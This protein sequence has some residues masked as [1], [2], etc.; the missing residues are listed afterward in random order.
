MSET[1]KPGKEKKIDETPKLSEIKKEDLPGYIW[2]Y[3][4]IHIGVGLLVLFFII[5]MV[6]GALTRKE[7][8]LE[9][10][11]INC[12]SLELSDTEEI[13]DEFMEGE[14]FD[15]S[16]QRTALNTNL[17]YREG[18][19]NVYGMSALMTVLGS[20][21]LDVAFWDEELFYEMGENAIY[22]PLED[23]L[24][25]EEIEAL[26]DRAMVCEYNILDSKGEI[27]GQDSYIAGIRLDDNKWIEETGLYP[28]DPPII[29][30]IYGGPHRDTAA[31]FVRYMV[32]KGL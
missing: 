28:A 13:F 12:Y 6:Y 14:G 1:P 21:T 31:D 17:S 23:Y 2:D 32:N 22:V 5:Y 18:D 26:G 11:A 24:T 27:T 25:A 15:P 30:L 29:A 19:G 8:V 7:T 20:N 4:K 10:A 3:Y 16:K 9:V